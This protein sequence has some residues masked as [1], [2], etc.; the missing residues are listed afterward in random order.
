V[1][2]NKH[3]SG[4]IW[5]SCSKATGQNLQMNKNQIFS[6]QKVPYNFQ[7]KIQFLVTAMTDKDPDQ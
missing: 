6:L 1:G 4:L 2:L 5:L 3:R 7:V